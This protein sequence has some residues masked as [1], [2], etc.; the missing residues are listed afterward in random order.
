M[1]FVKHIQRTDC[2]CVTEVVV[3]AFLAARQPQAVTGDGGSYSL[4]P[5]APPPLPSCLSVFAEDAT[6]P[7]RRFE[8]IVQ[9]PWFR[10]AYGGKSL[11]DTMALPEA[12][13][14]APQR[15]WR[16]DSG[17][18]GSGLKLWWAWAVDENG[19]TLYSLSPPGA[20][21][22]LAE[23]KADGAASGLPRWPGEGGGR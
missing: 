10:E 12:T 8:E 22:A 14:P 18:A 3:D 11:G 4:A 9:S 23:A 20:R 17:I 13:P 2:A 6:P 19:L 21:T 15:F 1:A 7:A 16:V 5:D